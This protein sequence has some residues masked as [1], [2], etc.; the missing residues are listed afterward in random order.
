MSC[1]RFLH[2][3]GDVVDVAAATKILQE[4]LSIAVIRWSSSGAGAERDSIRRAHRDRI[5][6][7]AFR[8]P[9]ALE[10]HE[11]LNELGRCETMVRIGTIVI[12]PIHKLTGRIRTPTDVERLIGPEVIGTLKNPCQRPILSDGSTFIG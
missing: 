9:T 7:I 8:Y 4:P 6:T 5:K 2:P 3:L 1:P 12:E 11:I 10:P